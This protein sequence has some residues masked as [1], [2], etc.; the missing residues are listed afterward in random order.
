MGVYT[1]IPCLF[2]SGAKLLL[3]A[4]S[5]IGS[6]SGHAQVYGYNYDDDTYPVDD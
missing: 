5:L 2:L 1:S 3:P 4:H 6:V